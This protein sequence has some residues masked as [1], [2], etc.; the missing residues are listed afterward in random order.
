MGAV[1]PVPEA[2]TVS[3]A[4]DEA[5]L[6]EVTRLLEGVTE[7]GV[8]RKEGLTEEGPAVDVTVSVIVVASPVTVSVAVKSVV[9]SVAV[10]PEVV[11]VE[12]SSA[13]PPSIKNR[14][15]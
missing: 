4:V 3:E 1:L 2:L 12:E 10:G 6:F 13:G 15:V 14:P 7:G 11:V 8:V 9:V 5:V